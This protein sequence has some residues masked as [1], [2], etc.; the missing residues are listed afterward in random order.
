MPIL[1]PE[2]R[3]G[4]GPRAAG[5]RRSGLKAWRKWR[6]K[7]Q[8]AAKP[9]CS[10]GPGMVEAFRWI[11]AQRGDS[12]IQAIQSGLGTN[13]LINEIPNPKAAS[14]GHVYRCHPIGGGKFLNA[15]WGKPEIYR[16][17]RQAAELVGLRWGIDI[18]MKDAPTGESS[19]GPPCPVER[20][21]AARLKPAPY[22]LLCA[23]A[24][25]VDVSARPR[26]EAEGGR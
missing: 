10:C 9:T 19:Q 5:R 18:M 23:E 4:K 26:H 7:T 3:Q 14:S 1:P 13:N 8:E 21:R 12:A 17:T 22:P 2:S 6:D 24:Q 16:Y 11:R 15:S 20:S 25:G